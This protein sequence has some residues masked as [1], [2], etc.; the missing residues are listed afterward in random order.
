MIN[1]ISETENQLNYK[2]QHETHENV[3]VQGKTIYKAQK[4]LK[5]MI[6][7]EGNFNTICCCRTKHI[8]LILAQM[9]W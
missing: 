3:V 6:M 7:E 4:V 8:L 9:I 5:I 1:V 2:S